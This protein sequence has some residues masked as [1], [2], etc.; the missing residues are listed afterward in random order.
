LLNK[1]LKAKEHPLLFKGAFFDAAVDLVRNHY[2][3][4]LYHY[5][6]DFLKMFFP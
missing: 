6:C 4:I 1:D 5:V 3:V 2:E